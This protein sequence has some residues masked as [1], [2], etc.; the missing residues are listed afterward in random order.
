M[1]FSK[2][3]GQLSFQIIPSATTIGKEDVLEVSFELSGSMEVS[4]FKEPLFAQWKVLSGPSLSSEQV[5]VNGKTTSSVKYLYSLQ[6]LATGT[7]KIP[8]TSIVAQG[9]TINCSAYSITVKNVHHLASAKNTASSLQPPASFFQE[10][11]MGAPEIDKAALLKPGESIA[12]KIKNNLFV[13]IV[14]NKTTCFVGEPLLV[15]YKLYSRLHTQSK[16]SKQ[17]SFSGCSV[18]E[19]TT[20]D[21]A[22]QTE[23]VKGIDYQTYTIRKVQLFPLQSGDL[24]LDSASVEN[25]VTFFRQKGS[26]NADAET[27]TITVSNDPLIIHVKEFPKTNKPAD[28]NGTIGDFSIKAELSKLIDTADENNTLEITIQGNG[29]FQTINC[30]KIEWPI[31]TDFFDNVEKTEINKLVFPASGTKLFSIPFVAKK[32]GKLIIPPIKFSYIDIYTAQYKTIS[33]DSIIVD[34]APALK[35]KIDIKKLSGDITNHKYIWIVPAIAFLLGISW[36]VSYR[37]NELPKKNSLPAEADKNLTSSLTNPMSNEPV[38]ELVPIS[39]K[40]KLNDLL[41]TE[42]DRTFFIQAQQ[43]AKEIKMQNTANLS[44]AQAE[45]IIQQCNEALYFPGAGVTKDHV[46][47]LLESLV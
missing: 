1:L 17:P 38:I 33:S 46:F 7:L 3:N 2:S 30:P 39:L 34:I 20:Q 47:R 8:A 10:D 40:E 11:M 25:E 44:I 28:F 27:K 19:M 26:G 12:S 15:E 43:L 37:R 5:S 21:Q 41:T 31:H 16:V 22:P 6:P 14:T 23:K 35:N 36:W 18:Y 45:L 42:D 13:K 24:I 9:K 32:A 29:N 4:N